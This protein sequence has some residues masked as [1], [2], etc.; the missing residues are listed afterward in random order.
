MTSP[1]P[2]TI[3]YRPPPLLPPQKRKYDIAMSASDT[4]TPVTNSNLNVP[5]SSV[6]LSSRPTTP[7]TNDH[8]EG[9]YYSLLL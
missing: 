7:K 2:T 3:P 8:R 9:N 5:T 4:S 1:V 6:K